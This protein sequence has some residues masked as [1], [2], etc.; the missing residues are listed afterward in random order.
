MEKS[1]NEKF[2]KQNCNNFSLL[3]S[4]K[5]KKIQGIKNETFKEID[6]KANNFPPFAKFRKRIQRNRKIKELWTMRIYQNNSQAND[7]WTIK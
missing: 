7:R 5:E 3:Q 4:F 1:T 6:D 2:L